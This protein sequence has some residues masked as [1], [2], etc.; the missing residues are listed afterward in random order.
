LEPA[1]PMATSNE[2]SIKFMDYNL[3]GWNAF[4]VNKWRSEVI[5][6]KIKTWGPAVLGAQE[7]EMGGSSG[8]SQV[9]DAVVEGTGLAEAGGSQFFKDSYLE[10]LAFEDYIGLV[11]GY[12]MSFAK[13]RVKSTGVTFLFFNSHWKHGHGKAQAR[14]VAKKIVEL[15][16]EHGALPTILVGDTNQF[17]RAYEL[18]GIKYLKGETGNSPIVF[19]DAVDHDKGKSFSDNNNPNCRV[20]FILASKG[21]WSL[22]QSFIDREGMGS[23]GSASDHAPIMAELVPKASDSSLV[24]IKA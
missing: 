10:K 20:D 3:Y 6:E 1:M 14:I 21:D 11:G 16:K 15:R 17:C 9:R 24:S 4:N 2:G 19:V 8:Y 7:V 18:D 23:W 13:Y 12:W 22:V 5:L